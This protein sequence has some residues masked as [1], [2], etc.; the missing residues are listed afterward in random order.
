MDRCVMMRRLFIREQRL[1]AAAREKCAKRPLILRPAITQRKT[2]PKFGE[3]YEWQ[4]D[5]IRFF[6]QRN[7]F[8]A[9]LKKI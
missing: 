4:E 8:R 6:D 2:S 5:G 1:D 3:R 9:L 7:G